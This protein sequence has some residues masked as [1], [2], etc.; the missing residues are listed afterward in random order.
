[1]SDIQ[2]EIRLFAENC[3]CCREIKDMEDTLKF[4]KDIDHLGIWAR[5]EGMRFQPVKCNIMQLTKKSSKIQASYDIGN[6]GSLKIRIRIIYWLY[7]KLTIFHQG[8]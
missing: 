8:L 2:S 6:P 1:M 5:K 7:A 3:V 4:Q